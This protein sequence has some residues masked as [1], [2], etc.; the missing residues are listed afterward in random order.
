MTSSRPTA[1]IVCARRRRDLGLRS[2]RRAGR[3]RERRPVILDDLTP[4]LMVD[5]IG[6]LVRIGRYHPGVRRASR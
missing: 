6:A 3:G 4:Q 2:R 5:P 1:P